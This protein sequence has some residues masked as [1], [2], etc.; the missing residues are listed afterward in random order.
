MEIFTGH[1]SGAGPKVQLTKI[2]WRL[3]GTGRRN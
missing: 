3:L 2:V 1:P